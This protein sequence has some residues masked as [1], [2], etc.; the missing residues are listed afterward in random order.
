MDRRQTIFDKQ[1]NGTIELDVTYTTS[2]KPRYTMNLHQSQGSTF[3]EQYSIYEYKTMEPRLLYVAL[4]RAREMEQIYVC[5]IESYNAYKGYIQ[6]YELNGKYYI[7][8]T[9][10]L[11]KRKQEHTSCTNA[12]NTKF[13]N[14]INMYGI[15]EFNYKVLETSE[16]NNIKDLWRLE[17]EYIDK[18]NRISNFYN[19][20]YNADKNQI[21]YYIDDS[22]RDEWGFKTYYGEHGFGGINETFREA[23]Q[24]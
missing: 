22:R 21:C 1:Q 18:Y 23:Q 10:D 7:G 3:L 5:D 16:S 8:S 13:N 19:I 2:F 20:R 14:A 15:E 12:G 6:S 17:D 9:N 4:S 11:V 24:I